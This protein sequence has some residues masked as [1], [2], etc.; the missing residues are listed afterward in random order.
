MCKDVKYLEGSVQSTKY[1]VLPKWWSQIRMWCQGFT[2][3]NKKNKKKQAQKYL[4]Q[5]SRIYFDLGFDTSNCTVLEVHEGRI[6]S[7]YSL[8]YPWHILNAQ[9]I[10][11]ESITHQCF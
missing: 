6:S 8:L 7:V 1:A 5:I 9:G 11:S 3:K 4:E 2:L 10:K